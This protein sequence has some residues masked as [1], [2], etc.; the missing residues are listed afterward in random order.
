MKGKKLPGHMGVDQVT[1]QNL[2]VVSVDLEKEVLL[3][4]GS[5]PGPK[6]G[7]VIVKSAVKK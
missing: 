6:K 4:S 7:L 2:K 3:I 1:I 5:V